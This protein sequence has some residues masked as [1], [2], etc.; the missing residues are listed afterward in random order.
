MLRAALALTAV[1]LALAATPAAHADVLVHHDSRAV[2]CSNGIKL[3]VWYQAYSGGP[4]WAYM[5]VRTAS[6]HTVL[7]HKKVR[8]TTQ[9]RYWRFTPSTCGRWYRVHYG[10]PN[11]DVD[12]K[13]YVKS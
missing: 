3:G 12:Y 1:L 7:A 2:S 4:H 5:E 11:G 8:A 6:G 9:W 13:V 10:V